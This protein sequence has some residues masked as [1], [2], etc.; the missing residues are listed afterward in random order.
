MYWGRYRSG[1]PWATASGPW[2]NRRGSGSPV[3]SCV[4]PWSSSICPLNKS[5]ESF[6]CSVPIGPKLYFQLIVNSY[7]IVITDIA[8]DIGNEIPMEPSAIV[9]LLNAVVQSYI[10]ISSL[11]LEKYK[12]N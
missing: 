6:I 11:R 12:L 10:I 3:M 7:V 9:I 5:T 8:T 4:G 2:I 1:R